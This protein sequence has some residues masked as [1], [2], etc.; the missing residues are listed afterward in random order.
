MRSPRGRVRHI[1]VDTE[2]QAAQIVERLRGGA[3]FA[4]L[5]KRYSKDETTN[6]N[7]GQTD[8]FT[9]GSMY[10]MAD[11]ALAHPVGELIPPLNGRVDVRYEKPSY[12]VGLGWRGAAKQDRLGEFEEPTD[13]Y[14]LFDAV[15]GYRWARMGRIHSLT[16]RLENLT[17]TEYRDHLSRI[18]HIMPQAGRGVSLLYRLSF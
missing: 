18:K 3:D 10:G 14:H 5:A 11:V 9:P 7:G 8:W 15:A 2:T 6:W 13:G 4:A 16:L 17:D 12:F 1:V